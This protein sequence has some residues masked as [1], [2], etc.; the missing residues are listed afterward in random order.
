LSVE[1]IPD[2]PAVEPVGDV[3]PVGLV[4]G[5]VVGEVVGEVVGDVDPV[6]PAVLP[7]PLDTIASVRMK[8]LRADVD[9]VEPE[10]PAVPAVPAVP[11]VAESLFKQ[12][13]TTTDLASRSLEVWVGRSCAATLTA[14]ASVHAIMVPKRWVLFI[15]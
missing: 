5:D 12:P 6:V 4:V 3:D 7:E 1:L 13:V 10:V 11:V 9:A 14:A 15:S 2:V 8:L